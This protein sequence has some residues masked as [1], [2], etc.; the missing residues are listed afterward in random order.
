M[1]GKL[2]FSIA[3]VALCVFAI[4]RTVP[5][6]SHLKEHSSKQFGISF[7]IPDGID[8]YTAENPGPLAAQISASAPFIF[9]N[10]VFTEE[11]I[12]VKI[13]DSVSESDLHDFKKGID[14][15][16]NVAV[17]QYKRITVSFI[18]IGKQNKTAVEHVF[19]MKGNILGKLRQVTFSH[20]GKGFIFTCATAVER[21]D[22]AN[23]SFFSPLFAS[24]SF[25]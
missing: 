24:M 8:L 22:K 15:N 9:V 3:G 12:N 18:K 1:K 16:P 21:F 10:P 19:I 17:P 13:T 23:Q 7:T 4:C 14:N 5:A 25:N 11:N 20:K 6:A 2:I